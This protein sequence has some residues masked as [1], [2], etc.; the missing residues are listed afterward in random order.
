M[1]DWI[2]PQ[3]V[4]EWL[5]RVFSP[6]PLVLVLL[7]LLAGVSEMRF[8]WAERLLGAYLITTNAL[9]PES[10]AIWERTHQTEAARKNL[11]QI[12][13]DRQ[14]LQRE[15]QEA[16]SLFEVA[17]NI[18]DGKGVMLPAEA[19]RKLYT[20]LPAMVQEEL[21]SPYALAGLF[22]SGSW[23]RT[24][25]SKS[26]D[27]LEIYLLDGFNRVLRQMRMPL[28]LLPLTVDPVLESGQGLAD[29]PQFRNRTYSPEA[30]FRALNALPLEIRRNLIPQPARLLHRPGRM[31]A[32]AVSDE[33]HD[34]FIVI[35][36]QWEDGPV[37][38]ELGR[39][40]AVWRLKS[41]LADTGGVGRRPTA[42]PEDVE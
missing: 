2:E 31:A 35:A 24:Y 26:I 15:A 4:F 38:S 29:L 30:F 12:V 39:E 22:N 32:V 6:R 7:V 34:G 14:T 11:E 20:A 37:E 40:W 10:G 25:F 28:E 21:T 27:T 42:W 19:F 13:T 16:A 36:F 3:N 5:Q 17:Q 8:D 23:V 41:V 9:R 1:H 18:G 33:A